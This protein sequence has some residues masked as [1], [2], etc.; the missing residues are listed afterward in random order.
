MT[1]L[2]RLNHTLSCNGKADRIMT[3]DYVDNTEV[4][5]AYGGYNPAKSYSTEELIDIN[6]KAYRGIGLDITRATHDP[7]NHWMR[8][9][10]DNWIRFFHVNPEKWKVEQGGDTAWISERPF[11]DLESLKK[12]L[13]EIPDIE[14]IREWY[15][16][17]IKDITERFNSED[18]LFIGAVEGPICDAYTYID[19]ELFS[20]LLFDAPDIVQHVLECTH[21][22]S[23]SIAQI[24][25]EN[26]TPPL[27]FMGEDIAGSTGPIFSPVKVEQLGLE[28]WRKIASHIQNRGGKFIFHTDGRYGE[29]LDLLL[30]KDRLY[31]EA[32]NPIERS[33]CNDIFEIHSNWPDTFLFGNVCCEDTLPFG[34]RYD[35]EDETL[36]LIE[37]IGPSGRIFIGSSSE[38]H[39]S[40]PLLNIEVMYNTV[41]EFGTYPIDI[42]RI[43]KKRVELSPKLR[44]RK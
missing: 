20:Y 42:E 21:T 19:M 15:E 4:L 40:I 11:H 2:D 6:V 41:H 33:N 36:E 5:K 18:R 23:D 14:E 25:S 28:K 8:N 39:E 24:Y 16:P 3:Y 26:E 12:N 30:G 34:N 27:Q 13:P 10:V 1:N 7:V 35:V 29:L 43:K 22:Y 9:K 44:V 38:V 32:L 37:K 31:A 17:F